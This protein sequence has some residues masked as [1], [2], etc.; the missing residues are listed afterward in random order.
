[1]N[2]PDAYRLAFS[3]RQAEAFAAP[4]A[5]EWTKEALDSG[6]TLH[7]VA[8]ARTSDPDD[9]DGGMRLRGRGPVPVVDGPGGRWAVRHY[10]RGGAVAPLL[11]DRYLRGG[12]PRPAVEARWSREAIRR[13]IPTPRV[14]AGA[15]YPAGVFYRADL[16][17][18]YVPDSRDL[19]AVLFGEGQTGPEGGPAIGPEEALDLAGRLLVHAA[20]RGLYH[21][22]LNARNILLARSE[23][24]LQP[25]LVDLDR[26]RVQ[27]AGP[28]L[29]TQTMLKR[30]ERSVLKIARAGGRA[31]PKAWLETLRG[32]VRDGLP[33]DAP[34][35]GSRDR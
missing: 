1:M 21:P 22:D 11:G 4:D 9:P 16:V 26:C 7:E 23:G 31:V 6:R 15:V 28:D 8:M 35:E 25:W 32:A 20:E 5:V 12:T 27:V 18:E 29:V 2:V 10:H 14:V 33:L 3:D 19:A 24:A 13:G 17:T 34:L 30:L